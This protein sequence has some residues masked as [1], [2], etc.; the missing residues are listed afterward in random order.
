MTKTLAGACVAQKQKEITG[1]LKKQKKDIQNKKE[2]EGKG[3]NR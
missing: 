2:K 3:K 1:K